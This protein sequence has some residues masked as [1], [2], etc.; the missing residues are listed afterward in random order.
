MIG[1]ISILIM[2]VSF[3]LSLRTQ[4]L[5]VMLAMM[6]LSLG[7]LAYLQELAEDK[8]FSVI[9]SEIAGLT[10][11]I[12][13]SVEQITAA[14]S[15]SEDRLNKYLDRLRK[16]GIKEVS[17]LSDQQ[18]VIRSSNPQMIGSKLSVAKNEF[19]IMA[20]IGD[21]E[22]GGK[23]KKLYSAFVPVISK[24]KVEGY[25]H[26]R[27]YFGDLEKLSDEMLYTRVAWMLPIFGIG[28]LLCIFIAYQYTKPIRVLIDAIRSIS[29]GRMPILPA[30]PQA[31]ISGLADSLGD[32]ITKLEKQKTMEEKLKRAEHHAMLA[33]LASGIAH[34]I[35][36]PLNFISLSVDHL[37]T[38]KSVEA[39]D[40]NGGPA[41]LIRKTKAEIRRVNQMVNNFLD[42][43]RELVLNPI[44]LR[45]DLPVE[46][47]LELNHHLIRDR[48][49]AVVRDYCDPL[50][51][52]E[53]DID[54]MKSC[55]QN[56]VT[57]AADAMPTGGT[58]R[59]SIRANAE[60][61]ELAFEDTGEGIQP[62][63]LPKICEPY[64][65]TKKTGTGLGLAIAK[66][67]VEAHGGHIGI[68]SA[69]GQGTCVKVAVPHAGGRP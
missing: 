20:K 50:P 23:T 68:I 58:L 11:A 56:L 19:L 30:I 14:G 31:D 45:A 26:I 42:L 28:V 59:I 18:E 46:E 32:M 17:I 12:E 41:D 29:E 3:R 2:K 47:V 69:P 65:T 38:L 44:G 36:N 48:S 51:V 7:S 40:G 60:F 15:T 25:V 10:K 4:L 22:M 9:Q 6:I 66:R 55:F 13:I 52:V 16:R 35:R 24:E 34:E 63:D 43:G 57:N 67:I 62:D 1:T 53:I 27:M 61:V 37:G 54:R 64:F 5:I 39:A 8:A 21:D 33:Q 49:I